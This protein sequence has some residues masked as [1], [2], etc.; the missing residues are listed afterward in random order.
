MQE[1]LLITAPFKEY[2]LSFIVM[3]VMVCVMFAAREANLAL[4]DDQVP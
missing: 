1:M 4:W 3:Y 2:E